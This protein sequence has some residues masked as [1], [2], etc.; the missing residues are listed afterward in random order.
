M[1]HFCHDGM[2]PDPLLGS[3]VVLLGEL[4]LD[5]QV[6]VLI[7]TWTVPASASL[8]LTGSEAEIELTSGS[9]T[10]A[11]CASPLVF[12]TVPG[13]STLFEASAATGVQLDSATT[14]AAYMDIAQSGGTVVIRADAATELLVKVRT[15]SEE[16]AVCAATQ[17]WG[18]A[19]PTRFPDDANIDPCIM[20]V[21]WG[22]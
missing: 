15:E 21:C 8:T 1:G 5:P 12:D 10:L 22:K 3:Q 13:D 2:N 19:S 16:A 20:N 7:G 9:V 11:A 6:R 17:C 18:L 14:P 4:R